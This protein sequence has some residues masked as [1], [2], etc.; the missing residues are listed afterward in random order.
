MSGHKQKETGKAKEAL[1]ATVRACGEFAL[2]AE[3][4]CISRSTLYDWF[5]KDEKF[6]ADCEHARM[7]CVDDMM[8]RI[9]KRG[10]PD[11]ED[12]MPVDT[13]AAI[14]WLKAHGR[15]DRPTETNVNLAGAGGGPIVIGFA[16][17]EA[18]AQE[19]MTRAKMGQK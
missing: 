19:I 2:A 16:S 11:A 15:Y 14:Y 17:C 3:R 13:T 6:R 4:C 10:F 8:E 7:A 18:E 9:R 1:V 5:E 12:K